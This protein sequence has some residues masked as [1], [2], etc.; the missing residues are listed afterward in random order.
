MRH[1]VY[2]AP[3]IVSVDADIESGF[4]LSGISE[5]SSSIEDMELIVMDEV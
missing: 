5:P 1:S 4:A 3:E 2:I